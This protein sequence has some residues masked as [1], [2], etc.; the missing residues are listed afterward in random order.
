MSKSIQSEITK[1]KEKCLCNLNNLYGS[2]EDLLK[3]V[4]LFLNSLRLI[5]CSS[6]NLEQIVGEV[7]K[8]YEN[9]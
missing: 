4:I 1:T 7:V 9:I 5:D 3:S 6:K 8:I 2:A